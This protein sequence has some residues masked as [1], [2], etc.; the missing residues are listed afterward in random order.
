MHITSKELREMNVPTVHYGIPNLNPVSAL[1]VPVPVPISFLFQLSSAV[2]YL[3]E[4]NSTPN[5]QL[6]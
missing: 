3:T 1:S 6:H 5:L 4:V 2:L